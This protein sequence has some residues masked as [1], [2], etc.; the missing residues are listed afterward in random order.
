MLEQNKNNDITT[1]Q[2]VSY[3]YSNSCKS[4]KEEILE[5]MGFTIRNGRV[6]S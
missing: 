4:E 3:T 5:E 1:N 6:Y 2:N